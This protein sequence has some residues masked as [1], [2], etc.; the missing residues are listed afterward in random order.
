MIRIINGRRS[1]I[2]KNSLGGKGYYLKKME[3]K[4]L[5]VVP[6]II[7]ASSVVK[8]IIDFVHLNK[9]YNHGRKFPND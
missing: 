4:K 1:K 2:D 5:P 3:E 6:G 9:K 8:Q 7:L